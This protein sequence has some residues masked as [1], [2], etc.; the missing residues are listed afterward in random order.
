MLQRRDLGHDLLALCDLVLGRGLG[1]RVQLVQVV[2]DG[3]DDV[4]ENDGP[5]LDDCGVAG[6]GQSCRPNMSRVGRLTR[7]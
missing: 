6:L 7:S 5:P 2:G 1:R 3:R 4:G